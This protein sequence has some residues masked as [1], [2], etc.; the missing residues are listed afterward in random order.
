MMDA[1]PAV[2]LFDG[3]C[4]LCSAAVRFMIANDP[5]GRLRFA[6]LQSEAAAGLLRAHGRTPGSL[7]SLVLV[8]ADGVHDKSDAALGI[9]TRLRSPWPLAGVAYALPRTWRDRLYLRIAANRYAWFGKRDA[10]MIPSPG[11]AARF[12]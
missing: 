6:P 2:V 9:A 11:D 12:L 4:N 8:D 3:V 5:A 1:P 7:E 10:C